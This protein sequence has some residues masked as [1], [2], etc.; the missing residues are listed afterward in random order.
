MSAATVELVPPVADCAPLEPPREPRRPDRAGQ[1]RAAAA[2]V[3]LA[4]AVL[5]GETVLARRLDGLRAFAQYNLLFDADASARLQTFSHGYG[6]D[7]RSMQHPALSLYV[8]VPIRLAAIPP[9]R[10]GVH[11][12]DVRAVRRLLALHVAPAAAGLTAAVVLLSLWA[13]GCAL[14]DPL[15][16]AVLGAATF[17]GVV[18]GA[19]PDHFALSGLC[20]ALALGLAVVTCR[21]GRPRRA[22]WI[23]LGMAT[24]G[25]TVTNGVPVFLILLAALRGAGWTAGRAAG[26]AVR[27]GIWALVLTFAVSAVG[28]AVYETGEVTPV[29]HSSAWARGYLRP[30]AGTAALR[31][32]AAM[33]SAVAP[34][35]PGV[36]HDSLAVATRARYGFRFTLQTPRRGSGT[37]GVAGWVVLALAAAGAARLLRGT[38]AQRGAGGAA[39]A[40]VGFNLVLHAAWGG[41]LFLYSQHW[42]PAIPLL[43]GGLA[44]QG[45]AGRA[46][47]WGLAVLAATVLAWNVVRVT[48]MLQTLEQ[49]GP[50]PYTF[51]S[52]AAPPT[53]SG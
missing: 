48:Q 46:R 53:A 12:G 39:L 2:A 44:V 49:A 5:A 45:P 3:M 41:E 37:A 17:S 28:N 36:R 31:F 1:R 50:G 9:A 42:A 25:I 18:F 35:S 22:I 34:A 23:L 15:A 26:E 20:V 24:A 14:R 33:A 32:P 19:V 27:L 10:A 40:L 7:A 38:P 8:S 16:I 13:L 4:L 30:D 52:G 47:T 11:G 29:R 43:L 21:E 6:A 51:S